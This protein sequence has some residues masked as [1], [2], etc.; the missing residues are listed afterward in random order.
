V[1]VARSLLKSG[2]MSFN[3]ETSSL[4]IQNRQ[5]SNLKSHAETGLAGVYLQGWVVEW[6]KNRAPMFAGGVRP[7][8]EPPYVCSGVVVSC[9][10]WKSAIEVSQLWR[11]VRE[12]VKRQCLCC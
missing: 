6:Y 11:V 9:R 4:D 1:A 10:L 12:P 2:S 8:H 3:T 5:G 7:D